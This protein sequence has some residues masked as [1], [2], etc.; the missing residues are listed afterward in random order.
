AGSPIQSYPP[1]LTRAGQLLGSPPYMSPEQWQDPARVGPRADQYGL[2]LLA[3]EALTGARPYS[4]TTIEE[5][6]ECHMSAALPAL[7]STL[8]PAVHAVLARAAA[9]EPELRFDNL[10]DLAA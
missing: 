4:A 1:G 5:L 2:A 10:G 8:P 9:K 6:A 3:F 7:P